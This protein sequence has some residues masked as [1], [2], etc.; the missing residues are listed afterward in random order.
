MNHSHFILNADEND[1]A[2]LDFAALDRLAGYGD[3]DEA[4]G[5]GAEV[6]EGNNGQTLSE[7][8]ASS[9]SPQIEASASTPTTRPDVE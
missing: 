2:G 3:E 8:R 7:R 4:D 6:A 9:H 5:C 1:F